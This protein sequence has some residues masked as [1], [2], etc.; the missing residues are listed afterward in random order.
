MKEPLNIISNSY[1]PDKVGGPNKVIANTIKGLQKIGY[2]FEI[3][4]DIT[5]FKYNWIHDS[6]K[7][8]IEVGLSGIPAVVGPNI[9]VLPNDLPG[10]RPS[11]R[12]CV[13]LHPANWCIK[14]WKELGYAECVMKPWPAG[15]DSDAFMVSREAA[16]SNDV[17][18]Y[19][20]RRDP[21]LLDQAIEV[22]KSRGLNPLIIRFGQYDEAQ[23]K[24]V[25]TK[26]KFGIW[27][28]TSES[29]G[30]ALQ[31]ALASGLPLIVCD[32]NSLFESTFDNN[33]T[34]PEK[35]RSFKPTSVPYFDERC[36]IIINDFSKLKESIRELIKNSSNYNPREFITENL[37][38]EKQA[39]ELL[40]FF[41][42]LDL[43]NLK[44]QKTDFNVTEVRDFSTSFKGGIIYRISI[45]RKKTRTVIGM[46]MKIF[47]N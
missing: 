17:M 47:R 28:G 14:L 7:G 8:I 19:F 6:T 16:K 44:V 21:L 27:I 32:V 13:Y 31:E 45:I 35:L 4:K 12:N 11:L 36:G 10:F 18:I 25:L 33:Y 5:Q 37:S 23:F 40:S 9:A 34:F 42:N 43:K 24:Q 30:I 46:I 41:D 20:K 15:I 2:P 39:R 26:S 22:V 3:N 1:I 38:L 29:Q